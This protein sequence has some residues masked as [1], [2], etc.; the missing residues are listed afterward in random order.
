MKAWIL[1]KMQS[2]LEWSKKSDD[3]DYQ[4]YKEMKKIYDSVKD[5]K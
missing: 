1:S 5:R 2:I 4:G 3:I